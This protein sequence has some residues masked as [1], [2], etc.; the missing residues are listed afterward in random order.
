MND[1]LRP[2]G[3]SRGQSQVRDALLD[4]AEALFA[5][6]GFGA[7]SLRDIA[8][9]AD[10][11]IG[12]LTY[13]FGT[14]IGLLG[15]IYR[16]HCG[17]MNARRLELLREAQRIHDPIE[18]AQAIVRAYVIPAFSSLSDHDGG[19]ARFTRL[20]AALSAESNPDARAI[21]AE[22]FDTTSH[23]FIDALHECAPHLS[24]ADVVWRSQ[25]LL[26]SLYYTLVNPERISRLSR[27][28][29]DGADMTVAVD[30]IVRA[31]TEGLMGRLT[32]AGDAAAK[33]HVQHRRKPAVSREHNA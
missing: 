2:D 23:A 5:E 26:G 20:R 27:G 16:R 25:F 11:H 8:R 30:Q 22:A 7:V 21:I 19:G 1:R 33:H 6:S 9:H 28:E 17:P 15:E 10:A 3:G 18:R 24:R 31:A 14:K 13:H 12:S 4:A 32:E 29:A